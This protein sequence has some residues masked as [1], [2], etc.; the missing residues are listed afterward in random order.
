MDFSVFIKNFIPR[1]FHNIII[2]LVS[3]FP[4]IF[5][6]GLRTVSLLNIFVA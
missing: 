5:V 6:A 2:V 4:I 1:S 3:E